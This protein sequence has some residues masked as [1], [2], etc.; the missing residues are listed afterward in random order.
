MY[1][2]T[3]DEIKHR[4]ENLDKVFLHIKNP[5]TCIVK[6]FPY[7]VDDRQGNLAKYARGKDYHIVILEKLSEIIANFKQDYPNNEFVSYCDISPLPEVYIAY[8][9]GAGILGRNGLI[10]DEIYG[11][12]V[13]IGIILTDANLNFEKSEKKTCINCKKC[14][15]SCPQKAIDANGVNPTKCLSYITQEMSADI[16]N[17]DNS[18]YI[19]GCDICLDVCPM[20]KNIQKTDILEFK[21]NL[22][23]TL[24]LSDV[25]NLTRKE[26]K[27]R[28][29]E[30]AFTFKGAKPL[31]RNLK[32]KASLKNINK[33]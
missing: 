23:S 26:L 10:F 24:S 27:N 15:I 2:C 19:W 31:T 7:F 11:G 5:Q 6:T 3:F 29:P 8:K 14:E 22:I 16:D 13:F 20:N 4:I 30:R 18:R 32:L 9:S 12:Y 25:E 28:F 1:F 17:L 33:A 21:T